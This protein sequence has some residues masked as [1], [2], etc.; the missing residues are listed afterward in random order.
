MAAGRLRPTAASSGRCGQ[1][2]K[3]LLPVRRIADQLV[4]ALGAAMLI[5]S[6]NTGT[7]S[8]ATSRSDRSSSRSAIRFMYSVAALPED[9]RDQRRKVDVPREYGADHG[10]LAQEPEQR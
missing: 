5:I 7:V 10:G 8:A 2:V 9:Q 1:S 6:Q 4:A 3:G